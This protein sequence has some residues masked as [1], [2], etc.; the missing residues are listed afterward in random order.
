MKFLVWF[1]EQTVTP[2]SDIATE[3]P[4]WVVFE[5]L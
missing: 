2:G 1:C 3:H 5:R 4:Q